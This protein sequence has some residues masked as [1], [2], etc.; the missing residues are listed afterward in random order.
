M[1]EDTEEDALYIALCIEAHSLVL[2]TELAFEYYFHNVKNS[3]KVGERFQEKRNVNQDAITLTLN[4]KNTTDAVTSRRSDHVDPNSESFD[5]IKPISIHV[6]V[7]RVRKA[8]EQEFYKV[9]G[10]FD[11]MQIL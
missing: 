3:S 8:H 2:D 1:V 11:P 9:P 5:N 10:I 7:R 6:L 4:N